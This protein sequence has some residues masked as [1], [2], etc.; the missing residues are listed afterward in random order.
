MEDSP[1]RLSPGV[2]AESKSNT[3]ND[4]SPKKEG[5]IKKWLG[6]ISRLV[7]GN[8]SNNSYGIIPERPPFD[9]YLPESLGRVDIIENRGDAVRIIDR[10]KTFGA[11]FITLRYEPRYSALVPNPTAIV[12]RGSEHSGVVCIGPVKSAYSILKEVPW[13][14]FRGPMECC[15][16]R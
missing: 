16:R 13:Y 3:G 9:V 12:E 8:S 10:S 14:C 4:S 5:L 6:G 1:Q 7:T 2:E 11:Q 15:R